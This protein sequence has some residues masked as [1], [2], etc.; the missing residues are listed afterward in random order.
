MPSKKNWIYNPPPPADQTV[1][2][3]P[4]AAPYSAAYYQP[5]FV[6][7]TPP[8]SSPVTSSTGYVQE[9]QRS[10]SNI[11]G[12]A[13]RGLNQQGT[14]KVLQQQVQDPRVKNINAVL[15]RQHLRRKAI[16]EG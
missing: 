2:A 13:N 12:P 10:F 14:Q 5:V 7:N 15:R 11:P 3:T 8:Q 16:R 6:R 4:L 9:N 1:P